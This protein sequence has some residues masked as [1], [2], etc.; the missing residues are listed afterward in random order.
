MIP[1]KPTLQKLLP[2]RSI[3]L[4]GSPLRANSHIILACG[5]EKRALGFLKNL[6][7]NQIAGVEFVTLIKYLPIRENNEQN[8]N[9]IIEELNRLGLGT[10]RLHIVEF[11]REYPSDFYDLLTSSDFF[12]D[13]DY[14]YLDISAMSKLLIL[15]LL[16]AIWTRSRT[17]FSIIYSE[18][19]D[20]GPSKEEFE[21]AFAK[22]ATAQSLSLE[23]TSAGVFDPLVPEPFRGASP[24]G[25]PRALV[26]FLSFNKRQI[27]GAAAIVPYQF[28]VPIIPVPSDST[29]GWR[30]DAVTSVNN[31][32]L[33]VREKLI[34]EIPTLNIDNSELIPPDG[35]YKVLDC[36]DDYIGT[37]KTL[38][39]LEEIHRYR[40]FITIAPFGTKLQTLAV[41]LFTIIF[42]ETQIV[43]ASPLDFHPNYST[44]VKSVSEIAFEN[45]AKLEDQM[46]VT[47]SPNL[48][49]LRELSEEK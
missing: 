7:P 48:Q 5:F 8:F 38:L 23:F 32:G 19:N 34:S 31:E 33:L 40:H 10:E 16:D 11:S 44:D 37:L 29:M 49:Y 27:I 3:I 25:S 24:L 46:R 13:S 28:F 15:Y 4:P 26:S 9:T 6:T 2:A 18:A 30:V 41:F 43:Y 36:S 20:Y 35:E 12:Q 21:D 1:D 17:S 39:I 42:P 14:I 45:P 22:G 47:L